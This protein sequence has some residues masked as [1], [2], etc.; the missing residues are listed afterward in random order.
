MYLGIIGDID[1]YSDRF[2]GSKLRGEK[3]PP[4]LFL[5][6]EKKCTDFG[7]K[8]PDSVDLW[9]ELSIRNVV[10]RISGRKNSKIFPYWASFSCDFD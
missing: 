7:K 8:C 1:A 3:R 6:I 9:A 2:T 10:L 5:K 4:Q